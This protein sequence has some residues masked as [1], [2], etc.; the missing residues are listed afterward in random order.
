MPTKPTEYEGIKL[1]VCATVMGAVMGATRTDAWQGIDDP[2]KG[3]TSHVGNTGNEYVVFH[4]AQIL[5]CYV[6]HMDWGKDNWRFFDDI[7]DDPNLWVNRTKEQYAW[8][9]LHKADWEKQVGP[10][11]VQRAKEEQLARARKYLG[12]GFGAKEGSALVVEE[13][14]EVDEDEE[15]YGEYQ[16]DR[17][18]HA[19]GG[20]N[21]WEFSLEEEDLWDNGRVNKYAEARKAMT[22][23]KK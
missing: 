19:E 5:P 6:I 2:K 14:G 9:K 15:N 11:G 4:G 12:Y 7:P 17:T 21:F 20:L 13:I 8:K 10:G 1:I 22:R 18:D 3:A 16:A 23:W